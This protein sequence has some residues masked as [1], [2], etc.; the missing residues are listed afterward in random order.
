MALHKDCC[1]FISLIY[2]CVVLF[3]LESVVFIQYKV[4]I[5]GSVCVVKLFLGQLMQCM[6]LVAVCFRRVE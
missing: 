5:L 3:A 6:F 1:G 2:I 4:R